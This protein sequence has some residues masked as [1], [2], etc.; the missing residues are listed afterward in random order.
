MVAVFIKAAYHDERLTDTLRNKSTWR[1]HSL[2]N[3]SLNI[4]SADQENLM[5]IAGTASPQLPKALYLPDDMLGKLVGTVQPGQ[6]V[7]ISDGKLIFDGCTIVADGIPQYQSRYTTER[8]LHQDSLRYYVSSLAKVEKLNGFDF[9]MADLTQDSFL[10]NTPEGN[11][12]LRLYSGDISKRIEAISY[13][14]G[15]GKGLTPSGDDLLVGVLAADQ[16]LSM[17]PEDTEGLIRRRLAQT[18]K[19]TT[20]VSAHYL[21]CALDG[22]YNEPIHQL[23]HVLRQ[24]SE[25]KSIE[26]C[27]RQIMAIGHTSGMDMLTGLTGALL[28]WNRFEGGYNQWRKELS[29]L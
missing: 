22:L 9:L 4:Q 26:E 16:L 8:G 10:A 7:S 21:A 14:I 25:E 11:H 20:T 3:K 28:V 6:N 27:I 5:L 15:R 24:E 13:F 19:P 17:L 23:L 1:V 18:P 29:S 12:I 2:F